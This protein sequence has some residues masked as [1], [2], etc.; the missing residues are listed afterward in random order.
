[1]VS[2]TFRHPYMMLLWLFII[3]IMAFDTVR[4]LLA[5]GH[6]F[7]ALLHD[8]WL[9][10]QAFGYGFGFTYLE[11]RSKLPDG[12][13]AH[14]FKSISPERLVSLTEG[15]RRSV[16]WKD[17]IKVQQ[18]VDYLLFFARNGETYWIPKR[19]FDSPDEAQMFYETAI[20]YWRAKGGPPVSQEGV[21]PPPPQSPRPS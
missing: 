4:S 17:I 18:T 8:A 1:V 21:W 13:S 20:F 11:I 10:L 5:T 6:L 14:C 16:K 2:G 7:G 19:A 12:A 9:L 3:G 15:K